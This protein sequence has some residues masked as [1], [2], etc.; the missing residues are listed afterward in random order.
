LKKK[1]ALR[2]IM[3]LRG[4]F[5]GQNKNFTTLFH[6]KWFL[7]IQNWFKFDDF[8]SFFIATEK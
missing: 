6:G 5:K 3:C 4:H 8:R 7:K 1:S 2:A